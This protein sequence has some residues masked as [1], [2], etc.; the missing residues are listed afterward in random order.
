MKISI[1]LLPQNK[2][3]K[4]KRAKFFRDFLWQ[5]FL[6][7]LPLL[8]LVVILANVFHLLTLQKEINKTNFALQQSQDQYQE[9]SGY[10]DNFKKVNENASFLLKIKNTHLK[11]INVLSQLSTV[12]PEGVVVDSFA[13]KEFGIFLVGKAQSRDKLLQ[14]K[15]NLDASEC[16]E[17]INVPLANLVVKE[18]VDFQIDLS[19]KQACLKD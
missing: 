16:F 14:F 12:T 7:M 2:K 4:L 9:L 18:D 17:N 5:E 10:D 3:N 8:I 11:W 6:L 19:V 1:D 13:S 15:D